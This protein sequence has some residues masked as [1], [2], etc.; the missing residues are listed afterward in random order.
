MKNI[1]R[2][3]ERI[4]CRIIVA[5]L[6]GIILFGYPLT[7]SAQHVVRQG[8]FVDSRYGHNHSYPSRGSFVTTLPRDHRAVVYRGA[9]YYFQVGVWYRPEGPRFV[10][11]VP[12][13]GLVIPFLPPYYSMIWVGGFPYYYANEVYYTPTVGGY[14]VVAP[15]QEGVVSQVPPAASSAPTGERLF[16]YPRKGQ[17][18]QQQANDRYQC[19][20]WAVGQTG[21]DPTQPPGG[22]PSAQKYSDY[23]CAMGACLDARGYVVK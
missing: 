18:E 21:Y 10:I 8:E 6:S 1:P 3:M 13:L 16:I 5:I 12:P 15:P 19:H 4:T 22:A 14:M 9:P 23:Q 17:S 11:I 20:Q 7:A 2:S